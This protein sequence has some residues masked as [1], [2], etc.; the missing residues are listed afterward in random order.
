M[1][2]PSAGRIAQRS[3]KRPRNPHW[4]GLGVEI[5]PSHVV[6]LFD[7]GEYTAI[8]AA[9]GPFRAATRSLTFALHNSTVG[10]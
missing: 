7:G 8:P 6:R 10:A 3:G 5:A 1:V 9:R 2:G 4:H